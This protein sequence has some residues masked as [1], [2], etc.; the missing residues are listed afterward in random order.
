MTYLLPLYIFG[1]VYFYKP[2]MMESKSPDGKVSYEVYLA[3]ICVIAA[4]WPVALVCEI[5]SLF[6][7]GKRRSSKP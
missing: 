2:I 5:T 1:V 3:S 7:T 6:I 4:L